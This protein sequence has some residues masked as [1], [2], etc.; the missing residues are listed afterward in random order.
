VVEKIIDEFI[1]IPTTIFC[2]EH[3][4]FDG[5]QEV[6]KIQGKLG[7]SPIDKVTYYSDQHLA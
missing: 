7:D 4:L 1:P 5:L 2:I 6:E 3:S